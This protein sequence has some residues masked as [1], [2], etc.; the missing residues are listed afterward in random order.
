[1]GDRPPLRTGDRPFGQTGFGGIRGG[2][3]SS[4]R[5]RPMN[6]LGTAPI[7]V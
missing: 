6:T 3:G 4:M 1:M 2:L 7:R 5:G